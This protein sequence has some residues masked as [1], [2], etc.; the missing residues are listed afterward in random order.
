[1]ENE[2]KHYGV[3]GMKWGVRKARPS[4]ADAQ[5]V[6]TIR[7]KKVHEMSNQEL[8]EANNRLELENKYKNFTKKKSV[9]QKALR[10]MQVF[11]TTVGTVT[12]AYAASKTVR[13][14]VNATL[15]KIGDYVVK[16]ITGMRID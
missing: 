2:L 8:R 11:T 16:D 3:L 4:S 5:K 15:N 1:M 12:A 7:K 10:G 13:K 6:Q 9:G 14:A